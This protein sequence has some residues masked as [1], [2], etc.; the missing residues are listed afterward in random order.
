LRLALEVLGHALRVID[1]D[2]GGTDVWVLGDCREPEV[3]AHGAR[4]VERGNRP[5]QPEWDDVETYSPEWYE[6]FRDW[7]LEQ[8]PDADDRTRENLDALVAYAEQ[9]EQRTDRVRW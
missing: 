1:E 4:I 6:R 9:A 8:F 5:P 2:A 7:H 3:R